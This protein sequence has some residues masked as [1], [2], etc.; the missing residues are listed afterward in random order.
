MQATPRLGLAFLVLAGALALSA[1]GGGG[2]EEVYYEE[3]VIYIPAGD[4]EVDNQTDLSGSFEALYFFAMTPAG[5]GLWTG[6][7]LPFDTLPGEIVY[8]GSFEEDF[9]DAE[10]EA[11]LGII[12]FFDVFVEGGW[13]TTF[14]IF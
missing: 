5:T 1:C 2:Y 6:N 8:V 11:D 13:T 12:D 7:L 4:V 3:T 9:Y 10:A 14:E